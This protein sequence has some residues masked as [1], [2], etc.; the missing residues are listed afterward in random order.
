MQ[1]S[2]TNL[3]ACNV[4]T[5]A[6][7]TIVTCHVSREPPADQPSTPGYPRP[8]EKLPCFAILAI[9]CKNICAARLKFSQVRYIGNGQG[10]RTPPR[11]IGRIQDPRSFTQIELAD[12]L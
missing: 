9:Q 8:A 11:R 1:Y 7:V 10:R 6:R 12:C 5:A 4:N 3:A 2:D